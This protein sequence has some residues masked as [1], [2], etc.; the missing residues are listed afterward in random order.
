M[1]IENTLRKVARVVQAQKAEIALLRAVSDGMKVHIEQQER[2]L[3]RMAS[4]LSEA[5][6]LLVAIPE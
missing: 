6:A 5:E 2:Q 1:S 4:A 3:Q